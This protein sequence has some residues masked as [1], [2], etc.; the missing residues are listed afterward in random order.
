[1]AS[2]GG[3]GRRAADTSASRHRVP[4]GWQGP[5]CHPA[6]TLARSSPGECAPEQE[7]AES[8]P[9]YSSRRT[10]APNVS[11]PRAGRVTTASALGGV[12]G[13]DEGDDGAHGVA[14][15]AAG[16]A[17]EYR[18][19][20][21][22]RQVHRR[23]LLGCQGD[24]GP[25]AQPGQRDRPVHRLEAAQAIG[26][27]SSRRSS[28][29][30]RAASERWKGTS[31]IALVPLVGASGGT[32]VGSGSATTPSSATSSAGQCPASP[33]STPSS[34]VASVTSS[35]HWTGRWPPGHGVAGFL[36][37]VGDPLKA[38]HPAAPAAPHGTAAWQGL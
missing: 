12:F 15:A 32:G 3:S 25:L 4:P 37:G 30:A 6:E 38:P 22:Q 14:V 23:L 11:K 29:P 16:P 24:A 20:L 13:A 8:R 17:G 9:A 21:G 27:A 18:H 19:P 34:P 36:V 1:M 5:R 28:P 35:G 10:A 31:K 33:L 2:V 26:G 7:Q